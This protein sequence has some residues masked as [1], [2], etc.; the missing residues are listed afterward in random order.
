MTTRNL[1]I[2]TKK[3]SKDQKARIEKAV[4]EGAKKFVI[5]AA[6]RTPIYTGAA[7]SAY[8]SFARELG[9]HAAIGRIQATADAIK[10]HGK[11]GVARKQHEGYNSTYFGIEWKGNI[12]KFFFKSDLH[13]LDWNDRTQSPKPL[14]NPTPWLGFKYGRIAAQAAF[15]KSLRASKLKMKDYI[16]FTGRV[17]HTE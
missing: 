7:K 4:T 17:T 2:D 14:T 8:E 10:H 15:Y 11:A 1:F 9:I 5:T 3:F 13:H 16:K 12:C 6:G